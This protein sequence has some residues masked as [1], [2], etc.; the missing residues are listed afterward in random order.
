MKKKNL[1]WMLV[2]LF[3]LSACGRQNSTG[4]QQEENGT[5]A[6]S[7]QATEKRWTEPL[8]GLKTS[9]KP[10][11]RAVAVMVNNHPL[12][13]TQSGL[14]SADIV[15]EALA[16]GN[17]TRF[18]AIFESDMPSNIGPIRSARP[19]FIKLAKGYNALYIAHGYSPGAKKLLDSGYVDEL[20]GMQYDGT[21]FYRSSARKA[22]HNSYITYKN[23]LKGA[24]EKGYVMDNAPSPLPFMTEK[25]VKNISG[26]SAGKISIRYSN[27]S[28]LN[29]E[30]RYDAEKQRYTRYSGGVQTVDANNNQPVLIDNL[31]IVA[32]KHKLIDSYGRRDIDLTSGGKAYLIQKGKLQEV[33]WEND[34]G[35]ILPYKDGEPIKLVPGKT[36]I[37]IVQSLGSVT[38]SD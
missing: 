17:I 24:K 4:T 8:T 11:R 29:A 32:A 21:L 10:D 25:E 22:P 36:W 20:N 28:N 31:F 1:I 33:E 38:V 13:R 2:L 15:Y 5:G 26:I 16:E 27:Q 34:N 23:I 18:V 35:R 6:K 9:S 7:L 37:N 12:A 19:Y 14:C 30:Y 3:V